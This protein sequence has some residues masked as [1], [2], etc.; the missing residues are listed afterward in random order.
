MGGNGSGIRQRPD[1]S[2]ADSGVPGRRRRQGPARG[3]FPCLGAGCGSWIKGR[4]D[5]NAHQSAVRSRSGTS[6]LFGSAAASIPARPASISS[7]TARRSARRPATTA[8][9]CG[10]SRST[11]ARSR[12]KR[13]GSNRRQANGPVGE[14][15]HRGNRLHGPAQSRSSRAAWFRDDGLGPARTAGRPRSGLYRGE[16]LPKELSAGSRSMRLGSFD[17]TA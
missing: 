2:F 9:R 17:N 12:A 3:Q 14:Y 7:W 8:T 13:P 10:G 1:P 11:S 16:S 6:S 15:R 4:P 5:R